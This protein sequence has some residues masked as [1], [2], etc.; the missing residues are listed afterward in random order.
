M[1]VRNPTA[2]STQVLSTNIGNAN[3]SVM[4]VT[5]GISVPLD[6]AAILILWFVYVAGGGATITNVTMRLR[7]GSTISGLLVNVTS[8]IDATYTG[9]AM[10]RTG[11]YVDNAPAFA[12]AQYCVT[13]QFTGN[14]GAQLT[15]D[16]FI[17]AIVL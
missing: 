5:P 10:V 9:G 13:M 8:W 15:Q 3:E 14:T 16:G 4:L 1:G 17:A 12:N 11:Q 6:S 7:R 2:Y